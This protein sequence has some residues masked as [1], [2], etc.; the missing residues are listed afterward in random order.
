MKTFRSNSAASKML[1]LMLAHESPRALLN[2]QRI[3]IDKSLAWSN[4]Y[5]SQPP[6]AVAESFVQEGFRAVR[7]SIVNVIARSGL[8]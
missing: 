3:D 5:P 6:E 4:Y 1:A 8:G 2:G 7:I